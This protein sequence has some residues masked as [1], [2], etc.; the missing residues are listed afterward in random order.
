MFAW[1]A[2]RCCCCLLVAV[3]ASFI[4]VMRA[5]SRRMVCMVSQDVRGGICVWHTQHTQCTDTRA[6]SVMSGLD[7]DTPHIIH[8]IYTYMCT[9]MY[10]MLNV[11]DG[12]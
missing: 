4:Y 12:D 10:G 8:I 11:N 5:I 3:V 2:F 9:S 6:K 1:R 7:D